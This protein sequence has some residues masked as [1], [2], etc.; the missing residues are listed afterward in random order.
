MDLLHVGKTTKEEVF[1]SLGEPDIINADD[2]CI[3]YLWDKVRLILIPLVPVQKGADPV[4][5]AYMYRTYELIL[6]FD[7]QGILNRKEVRKKIKID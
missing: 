7:D 1:V 4:L 2:R 6:C 5:A 3:I